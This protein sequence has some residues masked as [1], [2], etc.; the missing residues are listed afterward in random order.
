M[1]ASTS[2]SSSLSTAAT[3]RRYYIIIVSSIQST[4]QS[5]KDWVHKEYVYQSEDEAR[6]CLVNMAQ[7]T[8]AICGSSVDMFDVEYQ[9]SYEEGFY[10]LYHFSNNYCKDFITF[11]DK[12]CALDYFH[13]R[14]D[15]QDNL[16]DNDIVRLVTKNDSKITSSL[17]EYD[18]FNKCNVL[19]FPDHGHRWVLV[20][21]VPP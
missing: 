17:Y 4:L 1:E 15:E 6:S 21:L 14:C 18:M 7:E 9:T 11:T 19:V 12:Q 2:T 3:D 10:L 13:N 20:K 5:S 8:T 16:L